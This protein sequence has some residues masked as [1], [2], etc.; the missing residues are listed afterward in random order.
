[1]KINPK[2]SARLI[3]L[4][5]ST[6]AINANAF[7]YWTIVDPQKV[8]SQ[9]TQM[10]L[11]TENAVV[12]QAFGW[13]ELGME[14]SQL[15]TEIIN[16]GDSTMKNIALQR[17]SD[18]N[19]HNLKQQ[20]SNEPAIG[21]CDLVQETLYNLT[22]DPCTVYYFDEI[23]DGFALK[24]ESEV[25]SDSVI[26]NE[27]LERAE[28]RIEARE[29]VAS[30]SDYNELM[31]E[32]TMLFTETMGTTPYN[33][34]TSEDREGMD[35]FL[36]LAVSPT[37]MTIEDGFSTSSSDEQKLWVAHKTKS[38]TRQELSYQTMQAAYIHCSRNS[39]SYSTEHDLWVHH[40]NALANLQAQGTSVETGAG[41][42]LRPTISSIQRNSALDKARLIKLL[43]SQLNAA[44]TKETNLGLRTQ[45][46]NEIATQG[47]HP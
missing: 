18:T 32:L 2:L 43:Y 4:S 28:E 29:N 47:L 39:D 36:E 42:A 8:S 1:M 19:P 5:L 11:E 15:W 12:G 25:D 26:A 10:A 7:L 20:Q 21:L 44:L 35:S 46:L 37:Q 41:T 9:N 23:H 31:E 13:G 33:E 22:D 17:A 34:I 24:F 6:V 38:A 14:I 45:L 27:R 30:V 16:N 3:A 40:S